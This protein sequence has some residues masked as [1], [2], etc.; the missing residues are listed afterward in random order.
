MTHIDLFLHVC[1]SDNLPNYPWFSLNNKKIIG[2]S[3][4]EFSGILIKEFTGLPYKLYTFKMGDDKN[5]KME[6]EI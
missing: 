2:I 6:K 1:I 3:K 5:S 4:D